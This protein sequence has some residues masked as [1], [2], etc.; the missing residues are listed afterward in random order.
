MRRYILC[1]I[2]DVPRRCP[3]ASS[4]GTAWSAWIVS[5]LRSAGG[6][7]VIIIGTVILTVEGTH[8]YRASRRLRCGLRCSRRTRPRSSTWLLRPS[9]SR[10]QSGPPEAAL[11]QGIRR[12]TGQA[13]LVRSAGA[14]GRIAGGDGFASV[15]PTSCARRWPACPAPGG[16]S[17]LLAGEEEV[18]AEARTAWSRLREAHRRC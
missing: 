9:S 4:A 5:A 2:D 15:P 7:R 10:Q 13:E 3:A 17:R 16:R 8:R 6:D 18:R 11:T 1:F 14:P 12:S